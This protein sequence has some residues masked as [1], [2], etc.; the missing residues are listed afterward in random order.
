METLHIRLYN[1]KKFFSG[2]LFVSRDKL[3]G[4]QKLERVRYRQTWLPRDPARAKKQKPKHST[5]V[6]YSIL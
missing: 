4:A 5:S 1:Q 6:K 3:H 2:F